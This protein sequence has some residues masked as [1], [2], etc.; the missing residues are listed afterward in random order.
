MSCAVSGPDAR[1]ASRSARTC[2]SAGSPRSVTERLTSGPS[3]AVRAAANAAGGGGKYGTACPSEITLCPAARSTAAR[4]FSGSKGGRAMARMRSR[5]RVTGCRFYA[6]A[7]PPIGVPPHRRPGTRGVFFCEAASR[8]RRTAIARQVA[9]TQNDLNFAISAAPRETFRARAAH[10]GPPVGGYRGRC[11]APGARFRKLLTA[12]GRCR[13]FALT[14]AADVRGLCCRLAG[15]RLDEIV[16]RRRCGQV[17]VAVE[18]VQLEYVMVIPRT[19]RRAGTHV[20]RLAREVVP[21]HR[22]GRQIPL[23]PAIG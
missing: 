1:D 8:L 2:R 11:A 21:H 19:R 18:R 10:I 22:S 5:M 9:K 3:S 16:A 13:S 17:E 6:G 20:A 12:A 15:H 4:A 23:R 14:E 7:P